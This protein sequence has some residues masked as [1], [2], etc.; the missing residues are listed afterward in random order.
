MSMATVSRE[1]LLSFSLSYSFSGWNLT[2]NFPAC[3]FE[4]ECTINT[5]VPSPP[6]YIWRQISFIQSFVQKK[7]QFINSQF[8]WKVASLYFESSA[9]VSQLKPAVCGSCSSF[10]V[11]VSTVV[12][13]VE[14]LLQTKVLLLWLS[15]HPESEEC[16]DPATGRPL[17]MCLLCNAPI[18]MKLKCVIIFERC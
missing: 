6:K 13:I 16:F 15:A 7:K 14:L 1:A 11:V 12:S 18:Q 9:A 17:K 10:R 4:I 2:G 8:E 5:S 3:M